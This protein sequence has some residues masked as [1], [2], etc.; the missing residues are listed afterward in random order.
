[1]LHNLRSQQTHEE[2]VHEVVCDIMLNLFV[3]RINVQLV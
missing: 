3:L 2:I 1:M